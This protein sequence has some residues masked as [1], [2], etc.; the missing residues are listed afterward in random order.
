MIFCE[1]R[2]ILEILR[3][4]AMLSIQRLIGKNFVFM[5]NDDPKH[6]ALISES[7]K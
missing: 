5:Q 2:F 7:V 3:E 6:S 4:N 1:K